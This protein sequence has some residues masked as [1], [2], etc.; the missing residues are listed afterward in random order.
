MNTG[1]LIALTNTLFNNIKCY[2]LENDSIDNVYYT[3]IN[4]MT[5]LKDLA[6]RNN[7]V[8]DKLI[9]YLD[10]KSSTLTLKQILSY[11]KYDD[12]NLIHFNAFALIDTIQCIKN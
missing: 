9:E 12:N 8:S 4:L 2:C 11:I 5:D 6:F 3:S 7:E 10:K 1:K